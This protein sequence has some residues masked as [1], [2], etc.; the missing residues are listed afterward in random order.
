MKPTIILAFA[1]S[2]EAHLGLLK[3]ESGQLMHILGPLH[4][5]GAIEVH[6]EE[7][8][9]VDELV[10][11]FKRFHQRICIF[12]YAGHAGGEGLM[13]EEGDAGAE[14]LAELLHMQ[15]GRLSLVFLN[16]CSTLPQ[17]DRLMTLGI[18][19]VIATSVPIEDRKAVE[20]AAWFYQ[21]LIARRTLGD[22]FRLAAAALQMKFSGVPKPEI[23]THR[24]ERRH[25]GDT[26]G[27]ALPWGLY[28]HDTA[29]D[30]LDWR[31]PDTPIQRFL[32]NPLSDYK[33]NDYLPKIL[34]AMGHYDASVKATIEEIKAGKRDRRTVLPYIVEQLPWTVGAQLQKLIANSDAMRSLG[35]ERLQQIV[36]AYVITSQVLLYI[37][38]SQ[39]WEERRQGRI[40]EDCRF[41]IDV[42]A[43]DEEGARYYDY[44]AATINA[45]RFFRK[46]HIAPF[47]KE[48]EA[49]LT[50]FAKKEHLYKA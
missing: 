16:G 20:F 15:A 13:L 31:I 46:Q 37:Q 10:D 27:E 41:L 49:F 3:S 19:A 2:A 44:V 38:L 4:D 11:V 24:G 26:P 8:T 1:N 50:S 18:K 47:V 14:G 6:R 28:I 48:F 42:L 30:I 36:N 40:T 23:V 29:A 33:A 21:Q 39:L 35:L 45:G 17:V 32:T 34:G 7:S 22:A 5:K 43:L 9:T 25:T 12:H